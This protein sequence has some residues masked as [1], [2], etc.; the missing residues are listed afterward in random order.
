MLASSAVENVDFVYAD[1]K[2]EMPFEDGQFDL[3]Y[4][5]RG[6]A[7]IINHGRLLTSEGVIFDIHNQIDI[8]EKRLAANGFQEIEIEKYNE[9]VMVFPNETE[10]AKFLSDTPGNPDYTSP[11]RS[12]EF[13]KI[14]NEHIIDGKIAVRELKYIWKAVKP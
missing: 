1:T 9:A 6:P 14:L 11:E 2:S 3:I 8:V 7:S 12:A 10:F 13:E 4:D 5:R